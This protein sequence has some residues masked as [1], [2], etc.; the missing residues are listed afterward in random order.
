MGIIKNIVPKQNFELV[1]ERLGELLKLELEEQKFLQNF[2][3]PVNVYSERLD[4]FDHSEK[5][6]VNV[7]YDSSNDFDETQKGSQAKSRYFVDVFAS[8][9]SGNGI[10]GSLVSS[11][12]LHK[13]LG[14]CRYILS[15]SRYRTLGF[16]PGII[17]GVAV[18]SI[19]IANLETKSS[20]YDTMGR[21][22]VSVKLKEGQTLETGVL[23]NEHFTGVKLD[24]TDLG[25]KYEITN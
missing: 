24:L 16:D 1:N 13:F 5:V 19:Q 9:E 2:S 17:G 14:M 25:Y 18:E 4:V 3:D 10:N 8:G 6:M 20:S 22:S 11:K 12:R 7:F 21:L 15:D 23:M